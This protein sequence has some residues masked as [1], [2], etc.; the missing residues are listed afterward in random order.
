M[1]RPSIETTLPHRGQY[2]VAV[3]TAIRDLAHDCLLVQLG[4]VA[5]VVSLT[6]ARLADASGT[7]ERPPGDRFSDQ[8][9]PSLPFG[10]LCRV[11]RWLAVKPIAKHG[12][13]QLACS[14]RPGGSR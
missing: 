6:L 2:S 11:Q 14:E 7:L 1:L 3:D 5:R 4:L 12:G 8:R 9:R 10:A 13:H